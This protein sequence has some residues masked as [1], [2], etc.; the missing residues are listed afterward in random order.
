MNCEFQ[1]QDEW[2]VCQHGFMVKGT[3]APE[4]ACPMSDNEALPEVVTPEAT[5]D[6]VPRNMLEK[7]MAEDPE[8]A[9]RVIARREQAAKGCGGCRGRN[10]AA[11][12]S[13]PVTPKPLA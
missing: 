12:L 1:R 5:S 11:I 4:L 3:E 6:Y 8:F 7:R 13:V 9:K 2:W 10:R